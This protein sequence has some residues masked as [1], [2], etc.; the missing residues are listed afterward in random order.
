MIVYL[1]NLQSCWHKFA[2]RQSNSNSQRLRSVSLLP[3]VLGICTLP[4]SA[5]GPSR[6]V[7]A[8]EQTNEINPA[9]EQ[10]VAAQGLEFLASQ[11]QAE[12]SF[13]DSA[14]ATG[15]PPRLRLCR[16]MAFM[17]DG[18]LPGRGKYGN[19][20]RKAVDFIVRNQ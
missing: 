7:L 17:A 4:M 9:Q 15:R 20:V 12:G 10:A 1:N 16:R 19:N 2:I 6:Q 8:G 14:A 18:N 11:Q 5:G 3:L 13:G